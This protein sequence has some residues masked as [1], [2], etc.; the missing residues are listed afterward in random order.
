[1]IQIQS[2][3][4]DYAKLTESVRSPRAGAVCLF[5]GTVREVT[6]ERHTT[7]LDYECYPEMAKQVLAAIENEVRQKWPIIEMAMIHRTGSVT[8]GETSVAVAVSSPHRADAFAAGQ[9]AIDELKA[10]VPI[11]KKEHGPDGTFWVSE[12]P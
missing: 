5:L 3:P 2:S 8:V 12:R 10:R 1:M 11:W 6:G 9:Y 4:I 7:K